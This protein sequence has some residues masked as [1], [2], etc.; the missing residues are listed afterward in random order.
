MNRFQSGELFTLLLISLQ[1]PAPRQMRNIEKPVVRN[2]MPILSVKSKESF[3]NSDESD[4]WLELLVDGKYV[5]G[6]RLQPLRDETNELISIFV[7]IAVNTKKRM[8]IKKR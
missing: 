2:L 5:P 4:S 1:G 8:S 6:K 7:T 3:R